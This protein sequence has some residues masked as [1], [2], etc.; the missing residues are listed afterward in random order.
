MINGPPTQD[1]I[2]GNMLIWGNK[3]N[4]N[5]LQ[6]AGALAIVAGSILVFAVLASVPLCQ[7]YLSEKKSNQ[8]KYMY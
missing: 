3:N 6:V 5:Y 4:N 7:G 1:C 2:S 8:V